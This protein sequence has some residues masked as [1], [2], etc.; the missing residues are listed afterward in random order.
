MLEGLQATNEN[1][2]KDAVAVAE[3]LKTELKHQSILK[4][5]EIKE[6]KQLVL[7]TK[8]ASME[9]VRDTVDE[10][11]RRVSHLTHRPCLQPSSAHWC[12]S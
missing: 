2:Q 5:A 4:D 3:R 6:L 1:I 8:Q 9:K 11:Q 10:Y 12:C 7:E